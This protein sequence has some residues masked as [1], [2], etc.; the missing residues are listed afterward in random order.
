VTKNR[1][2][3]ERL[4][5]DVH[6]IREMS[7]C[8]ADKVNAA[9]LVQ[10]YDH[11]KDIADMEKAADFLAGSLDHYKGLVRLTTDTY[12]YANSMQ[13]AQ[14]RIPVPGGAGGKPANYH[15][16][17]LLPLYEKEL[18]DF[19]EQIAA[20]KQ[21]TIIVDESS[22]KP[23][24]KAT[25]TLLS[26]DA[27]VYEVQIGAKVFTDA[28][29]TIRSIAP[30]FAG[31]KGMRFSSEAAKNGKYTPIEFETSEPVQILIGYFQSKQKE[32]LQPPNLETDALAA[33]HGGTEPL[34]QNAIQI[35]S[36]PPVNVHALKYDKGRH[37]LDVR[38]TGTFV[39][40]GVIPQSATIIPR[41]AH[42]GGGDAK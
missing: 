19:Q 30:E 35:E 29:H 20:I 40:V 38:G 9:L 28:G 15:W 22:I 14:R 16:S 39:V 42:L 13:T 10:R 21:G 2:E 37:A 25:F 4:R 1:D 34:F 17:Q 8:Y 41:D 31:L 7:Q 36:L 18:F 3:F 24:P 5:N 23:L 11:S 33:E 32:Y 12:I 26:S 6:C 27:E